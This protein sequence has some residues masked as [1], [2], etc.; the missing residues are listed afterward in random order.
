MKTPV[1][2]L[3]LA[4]AALVGGCVAPATRTTTTA[5][6]TSSRVKSDPAATKTYTDEELKATGQGRTEDALEKRDPSIIR[7]GGR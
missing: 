1:I 6:S 4:S 7:R 2:F 5:E 3:I